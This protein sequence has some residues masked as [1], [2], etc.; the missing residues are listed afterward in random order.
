MELILKLKALFHEQRLNIHIPCE[1]IAPIEGTHG[2]GRQSFVGLF[3]SEM[4]LT[5]SVIALRFTLT[6]GTLVFSHLGWT[7]LEK[8]H[9]A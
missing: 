1:H 3:Y 8:E 5:T 6:K 9:M 7:L 2:L 4:F